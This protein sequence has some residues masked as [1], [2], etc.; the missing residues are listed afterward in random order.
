ITEV[1]PF[2][3]LLTL[4]L[5]LQMILWDQT[6]D[7]RHLRWAALL[8]G[9]NLAHHLSISLLAPGLIGF[10]LTSRHA[11]A[12]LRHLPGL[13]GLMLLPLRAS[14]AAPGTDGAGGRTGR[15]GTLAAEVAGA[16]PF[17]LTAQFM[18]AAWDG[19]RLI[20]LFGTWILLSIVWGINYFIFD[21]Q[22]CYIAA[23]I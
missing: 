23:L 19:W 5:L 22:V 15:R 3:C 11:R 18:A 1:Y 4:G 6:G 10:A 7:L 20:W 12:G 2:S 16:G 9:L 17:T 13:A 14:R 8:T 21:Y